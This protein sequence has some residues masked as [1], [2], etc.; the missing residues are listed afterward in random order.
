M[1]NVARGQIHLSLGYTI[2]KCGKKQLQHFYHVSQ[3]I[4]G[5]RKSVRFSTFQRKKSVL[6]NKMVPYQ[7]LI[8]L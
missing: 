3:T 7:M 4:C 6:V 1:I 2:Q 8:N 5:V